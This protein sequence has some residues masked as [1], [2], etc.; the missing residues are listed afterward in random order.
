MS[1][2]VPSN[3]ALD[4]R[5]PVPG[6]SFQ[7][8]EIEPAAAKKSIVIHATASQAPGEDGMTVAEYHVNRNGWGGVGV[9]FVC[10]K[11]SYPGREGF[12]PAGV[13]LHYVGDLL[14]W[15]AGTLGQNPGRIHIEISGLFTPGNGVPSEAQLRKV[16]AFI[17][18]ALAP[19]NVLPSLNYYSQVTYHNAVP[20]QN[21][22]CP[23]W[24]HPQFHEWFAY[25]QGGP[26]PSWWAKPVPVPPPTPAPAP[27]QGSGDPVPVTVVPPEWVATWKPQV[28]TK[29]I[30]RPGAFAV[31][32]T[33]NRKVQENIPVGSNVQ[34]G[35]YFTVGSNT[36]ARSQWATSKGIWNGVPEVFFQPPT[37]QVSA[38]IPVTPV[39][40]DQVATNVTDQQLQEATVPVQTRPSLLEA[41]KDA[42][43]AVVAI[44]IRRKV[45]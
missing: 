42:V 9:H 20:D 30:L 1:I 26:E 29:P 25:L 44:L 7:W 11:D 45:K 41:L 4:V 17:D 5:M 8:E 3:L 43:A 27:G 33:T 21:T 24:Q 14:T 19:N 35:G 2:E 38:P 36:Y 22:D 31:D 12:S 40:T 37:G 32:V 34:I 18:W 16:R 6:D 13:Q 39:A 28:E 15:R 23:G 10:T